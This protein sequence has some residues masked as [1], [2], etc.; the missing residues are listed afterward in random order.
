M[1]GVSVCK[2][3]KIQTMYSL[4]LF[5]VSAVGIRFPTQVVWPVHD[6]KMYAFLPFQQ[7]M[8]VLHSFG[9]RC[10][11]SAAFP[12][13]SVDST[14]FCFR[15]SSKGFHLDGHPFFCTTSPLRQTG[16][17]QVSD[18]PFLI[19]LPVV[20]AVVLLLLVAAAVVVVRKGISKSEPKYW[21]DISKTDQNGRHASKGERTRRKM[22]NPF[23]NLR[24]YRQLS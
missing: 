10:I 4:I 21:N 1:K 15:S 8:C 13:P 3:L 23:P 12:F 6:P 14:T 2:S 7:E 20:V 9:T 22:A 24:N 5:S 17:Q 16:R 19:T 11:P 18:S